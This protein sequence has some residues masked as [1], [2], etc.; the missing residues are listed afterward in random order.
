M[1]ELENKAESVAASAAELRK[2]IETRHPP[3]FLSSQSLNAPPI[4]TRLGLAQRLQGHEGRIFSLSWAGAGS[5]S[6]PAALYTL[7]SVSVTGEVCVWNARK[8]V[9]AAKGII[10]GVDSWLMTCAFEKQNSSLLGIGGRTG[11]CWLF[12]VA[13]RHAEVMMDMQPRVSFQAH[14]NYISA[15]DFPGAT[16]LLTASGD[17]TCRLWS[18]NSTSTPL[19]EFSGHTEDVICL[20]VCPLNPALFLSG[21]CD[22]SVKLWDMR[23]SAKPRRS[24]DWHNADVN[25][26]CFFPNSIY[27]YVSACSDGSVLIWDIRAIR[28]LGQ[29]NWSTSPISAMAVS[30]SGRLIISANEEGEIAVSDTLNGAETVQRLS[31]HREKVTELEISPD[32][33]TVASCGFDK[34]VLL[35][36]T[37]KLR[38]T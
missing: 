25:S 12:T 16:E 11:K 37:L 26:V 28:P 35:F 2:I 14:Q 3:A 34:E 32:G 20:S 30:M 38:P 29:Y 33:A 36:Q 31:E 6:N 27:T 7:A 10:A 21:S 8:G 15:L 1:K 9:A 4:T 13:C 17:C 24:F 22:R 5:S 18:V 23:D 19:R